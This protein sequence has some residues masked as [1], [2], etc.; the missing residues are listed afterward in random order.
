[1]CRMYTR[2]NK[3]RIKIFPYRRALNTKGKCVECEAMK[4][5][6]SRGNRPW[7]ED[8]LTITIGCLQ[9]TW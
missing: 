8:S 5:P 4:I 2:R 9:E 6:H 1:M 7:V 3:E